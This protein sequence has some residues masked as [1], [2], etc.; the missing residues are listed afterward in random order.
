MWFM[1]SYGRP[2]RLRQLLDAPGGWPDKVIVLVNEDDPERQEYWH[3]FDR[4]LPRNVPW[5][6]CFVPAGSRCADAHRFITEK[7]PDEAFY[8]LICDDHW[9]VT[10]G[11]H[12]AL[13]EAAGRQFISGPAGEPSFPLLRN[14]VVLGG[15]LVRA[16]SGRAAKRG[17]RLQEIPRPRL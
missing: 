14:V 1:P 9:P 8:G 15:D 2:E 5:K 7:Y 17:R 16:M 11:W 10:P 6:L 12:K 13:V 3:L 4:V